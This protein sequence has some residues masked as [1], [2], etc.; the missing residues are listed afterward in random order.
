MG[1]KVTEEILD[2]GPFM[3]AANKALEQYGIDAWDLTVKA[4]NEIRNQAVLA[5]PVE[6]SSIGGWGQA[7]A[8]RAGWQIRTKRLGRMNAFIEVFNPVPYASIIEYGT[9]PHLIVA[10]NKKVL[11]N[12][13]EKKI[14]G[15]V[16]HHP[17]TKPHPMLRPAVARG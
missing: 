12:F 6:N 13:K 9:K 10:K 3:V 16:V 11:A 1:C 17:G 8:L 2:L 14:F 4:A 5:S 15:K 7:G